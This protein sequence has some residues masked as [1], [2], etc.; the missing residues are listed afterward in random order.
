MRK[1]WF[2]CDGRGGAEPL[3]SERAP[4]N[5]G[6]TPVPRSTRRNFLVGLGLGS[7][8]WAM[9][10]TALSEIAIDPKS[11]RSGKNIVVSLFLRGGADGLNIVVPYGEDAYHHNRPTLRLLKP[12]EGDKRSQ[13]LDLDGF[14]GFNPALADL[15]P[16]YRSG[17]LAVVHA[18]GSGDQTR[19]HFEAMNT[20]ERG[21]VGGSTG[22]ASGWLARH[23]ATSE[24]QRTSPL[25]AVAF[26]GTMPDSLRGATDAI[27]INGLDDY[28][29]TADDESA[30]RAA[31]RDLYGDGKDAMSQA[32]SETLLVLDTLSRLDPKSYRPS[33]GA[34]YPKS[35]L[36]QAL[37]QVALLIRA[38]VGL[39]VAV[40]DKGGWD[41]HVA[42]GVSTGLL[43]ANLMD[44]A[45]SL[46][47]FAQ[48]LGPEMSRITL[49][50]Q[51]EFG[52]RLHENS[53]LGTDHGRASF[54]FVL[55]GGVKGGKV[56]A[57]WPGLE[58]AQLEP[59]GDLR[60]TTDYRQVFADVLLHSFASKTQ[61]VFESFSPSPTGLFS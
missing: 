39:E 38:D 52:R 8:A 54:M 43:S 3:A 32:G 56:Y 28:R 35:D 53:G 36:G 18:A 33:N 60:V 22:P 40:L 1:D 6:E 47:A 61:D 25:R 41:T 27:A 13:V 29:L 57:K 37:E 58:D 19:S 7:L 59:P 4:E 50:A 48:D 44:L 21:L 16:L 51:T 49:V 30:V 55:G 9:P 26:G 15:I 14:F 24:P 5:T 34:K 23:L 20:M 17:Q 11:A 45:S 42:Q 2:S 31:L 10:R 46:A 12:G